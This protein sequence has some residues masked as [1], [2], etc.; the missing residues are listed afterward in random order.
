MEHCDLKSIGVMDLL[1]RT[2]GVPPIPGATTDD[3]SEQLMK[4][5]SVEGKKIDIIECRNRVME[6]DGLMA[7]LQL[8]CDAEFLEESS[9]A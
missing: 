1:L 5:Y 2:M 6:E 3:W 4:E 8:V 9:T 7:H